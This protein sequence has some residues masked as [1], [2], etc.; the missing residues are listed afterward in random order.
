RPLRFVHLSAVDRAGHEHG[1]L[2]REY[3]A[4]VRATDRRLGRIMKKIEATQWRRRHTV[5]LVTTDHG[6]YGPTHTDASRYENYRIPFFAW[7]RGVARRD[8]Y[9][10]NPTYL[11]PGRSRPGY[12]GRQ[13]IR[14]GDIAN[15]TLDLLGLG[16]TRY[17]T[18]GWGQRL[19][20]LARLGSG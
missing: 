8:L 17:S 12:R 9:A 2:S 3:L 4:A 7:G 14:N 11:D 15:L 18:I 6:G 19:R 20:V 16:P 13:P 10:I 5:M 1:W